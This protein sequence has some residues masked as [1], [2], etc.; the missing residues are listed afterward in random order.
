LQHFDA[1]K[2][3][4]M[5]LLLQLVRADLVTRLSETHLNVLISQLEGELLRNDVVR[6][7]LTTK[8]NEFVKQ[9][10]A[11]GKEG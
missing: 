2:E 5:A 7:E 8:A 10:G 6:K 3:G 9:L 4:L 11:T 1:G